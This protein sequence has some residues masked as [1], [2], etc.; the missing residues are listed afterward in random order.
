MLLYAQLVILVILAV[1]NI[2]YGIYQGLYGLIWWWDIPSHFLGGVWVGFLTAWLLQKLGGRI[3]VAR[4]IAGA[5]VVG[6]VWEIFE[7]Y[8]AL[9]GNAF[10]PYWIDT[11][12]DL[13]IDMAGGALAGYSAL[14]AKVLWRK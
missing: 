2:W 4:S 11:I 10:M 5:L 3:S 8:F 1:L 14:R 6:I 9:G 13:I 7:H 12:K